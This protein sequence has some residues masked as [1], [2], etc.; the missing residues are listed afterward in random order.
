M[1]LFYKI[2]F[3]SLNKI[4]KI[5]YP[6]IILI[7]LKVRSAISETLAPLV[8]PKITSKYWPNSIVKDTKNPAK[9]IILRLLNFLFHIIG[10]KIPN[11]V[12][13]NKLPT[14]SLKK[15]NLVVS[16]Y[17]FIKSNKFKLITARIS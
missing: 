8:N 11:G 14:I 12:K 10:K 6:N 4:L 15:I 16:L 13:S 1:L 7:V 3:F 9:V 17:E 2:N 5:I